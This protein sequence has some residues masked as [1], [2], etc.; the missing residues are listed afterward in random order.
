M[1]SNSLGIRIA[2]AVISI[3]ML[4]VLVIT[5]FTYRKTEQIFK[6]S[7]ETHAINLLQ[8]TSNNIKIAYE[9]ILYHK[10]STLSRRKDEIKNHTIIAE[11]IVDSSYRKWKS[12]IID[13]ASAKEYALNE[14]DKLRYANGTGY[15]WINS[16]DRPYARMIMH[17]T[18]PELNG[19]ILDDPIFNCALGKDTNLFSAFVDVCLKNENHDGYV[20]YLWP[21][22]TD[23]GLT[24]KQPKISY[25]RLFKPWNWIIGTGVYIDDIDHDVRQRIDAVINEL[26]KIIPA[27]KIDQNGY[28]FIFN[29]QNRMLV[30][31]NQ[32]SLK[33]ETLINPE[34]GALLLEEFKRVAK[35]RNK[36]MEYLWDKPDHKGEYRF[37][38][39]VFLSY[40]PPLKWYIA[41][42]YYTDDLEKRIFELTNLIFAFS[43]V[44]L[45]IAI[46]VSILLAGKIVRPLNALTRAALKKGND[47]L[48]AD[49]LPVTGTKETVDLGRTI[50][51]MIDA[52]RKSRSLLKE[53]E[54]KFRA[55]F[56]Q[57]FQFIGIIGTD[58]T[59]MDV[60]LASLKIAALEKTE[61]IGKPIW[62]TP[63]WENSPEM[64]TQLKQ[65]ISKSAA[66]E[67]VRFETTYR[68]NDGS[69]L[70][71]DFSLKPVK[72]DENNV[73]ALIAEGRD[74]TAHKQAENILRENRE[75]LRTILDSI[76]DAV[77][78]TDIHGLITNMNPVAENLTGWP[79]AEVEGKPLSAIF[80]IIHSQT[81]KPCESPVDKVLYTGKPASLSS[82]TILNCRDGKQRLIAD[83]CAPIYDA[84]KM[85]NGVVLVFRD[86]TEEHALQTQLQ[87]SQKMDAIGQLAGGLAHDINNM[88]G[89]IMAGAETLE[90]QLYD[91]P[92]AIE[93]L[94]IIMNASERAS[95][96]IKQLL[97]FSRKEQIISTLVDVHIAVLNAI[98]L[99]KHTID[100]RVI[101]HRNLNP[102]I[103]WVAG[104]L[105]Q[106]QNMFLNLGINATHAMPKGGELTFSSKIIF[107]DPID[108]DKSSFDLKPG[109]YIQIDVKDTGCGIPAD[110]LPKIFEPFFTTR[111]QG[112]GSG[113]GLAAAYGTVKQH[114][115]SITVRSKEGKGTIFTILLPVSEERKRQIQPVNLSPVSGKGRILMVDDESVIRTTGKKLLEDLGYEV[116]LAENGKQ[117]IDIFN[118][119]HQS[120]DLVILDMIMPDL[121]GEDCFFAMK[122]IDPTV[123]IIISSGFTRDADLKNLKDKGLAGFV[124]K[125]YRLY[126]LSKVIS[127][128][129]LQKKH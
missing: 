84:N 114:R 49:A 104:D 7:V 112:E 22:P 6:K 38:K 27:I 59:V 113:L 66:G 21:K 32:D 23:H 33:N 50:N 67:L 122:E 34:T 83:S 46:L 13:E 40:F 43:I 2:A 53:S 39:K 107:L 93:L 85:M 115:G 9:S 15:F 97:A 62:Q 121:N 90:L 8:S 81:G 57:T 103:A 129:I 12:G 47:G 29:E 89:G 116:V 25:V 3:V 117:G 99:L 95:E 126:D 91:K 70:F 63:W 109:K 24:E 72:D 19:K 17:P 51:N 102:E 35:S 61:V 125:P 127:D 80:Q 124:R 94:A 71:A 105:S 120:F 78:A 4:T 100:K 18:L 128:V 60:N 88:L 98:S 11:A 26:N 110:V 20:D 79:L 55:V 77:V 69:K 65:A 118:K 87:H 76:G 52:I 56:N 5:L 30:H 82:D 37:P 14:L 45:V 123:S 16:I 108:C 64:K 31:P 74:I 92:E 68:K 75:N 10:N 96:L 36:S 41:S 28:F 111:N 54:E 42:S 106:L 1:I 58:G 101:I 48:P 119:E 44:S 73:F 86:I